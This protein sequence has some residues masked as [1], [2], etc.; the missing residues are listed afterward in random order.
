M[1]VVDPKNWTVFRPFLVRIRRLVVLTLPPFL[2]LDRV[3]IPRYLERQYN[4][5]ISEFFWATIDTLLE[6]DWVF[7]Q[8]PPLS[9]THFL[10]SFECKISRPYDSDRVAFWVHNVT[11][12]ASGS[13]I[14]PILGGVDPATA[15][16]WT[17]VEEVLEQY[18]LLWFAPLTTIIDFF[19]VISI[20]EP[21]TREETGG[22]LDLKGGGEMQQVFVWQEQ[23]FACEL[24][25]WPEIQSKLEL[26]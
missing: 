13:R 25:S 1:D 11:D 3:E 20:L 12:L 17:S 6:R 16:S 9:I 23:Y 24:P 5:G 21:K 14:P 26:R 8:G 18:P 10:G 7:G 15:A 4:F 2:E 22:F 19:P